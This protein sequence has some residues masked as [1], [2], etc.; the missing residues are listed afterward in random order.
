MLG[1]APGDSAMLGCCTT[2]P[3]E[4]WVSSCGESGAMGASSG[5]GAAI[6]GGGV[7]A[8]AGGIGI[9]PT[10]NPKFVRA[11]A[12]EEDAVF[13]PI[14]PRVCAGWDVPPDAGG[15]M[16]PAGARLAPVGAN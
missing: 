4:N 16:A 13:P 3:V 1:E 15:M 7:G 8:G 2:P 6:A 9:V 12:A 10:P 11:A 14:A 5:A